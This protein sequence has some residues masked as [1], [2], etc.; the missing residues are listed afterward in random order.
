MCQIYA[1]RLLPI[2]FLLITGAA[3]AQ[4]SNKEN[5]P[6]SRY[7]IGDLVDGSNVLLRGMGYTS[8]SYSSGTAVN[9]D[10]P[11]SYASLRLTT[12]E[13]GITGSLR[14]I[15]VGGEKYNTGSATIANLN[16][17]IPLGKNGGLAL[18]LR[19]QSK[20]F[21]HN[22][23]SSLRFADGSRG[24]SDYNGDGGLNYA[25]IGAAGKYKGF[26]LGF[27]FGYMFGTIRNT[28]VTRNIDTT[29]LLSSDITRYTKIGGIYWKGGLQYE[30]PINNKLKLRVG[31]TATINQ[32]LNASREEYLSTFHY[33]SGGTLVTDTAYHNSDIS[34]KVTLPLSISGGVMLG[35]DKWSASVDY[36]NTNWSQYRNYGAIDSVADHTSRISVGGEYTPNATAL[37]AYL[38]RITYRLGFYY[39][40]DYVKLRNTDINYYAV[41]LGGSLPFK[42]SAD[43]IHIAA[44]IGQRGTETNNLVKENFFRF[45]LGISL[46]S[47]WFEKRR[48]D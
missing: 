14:T 3:S 17:G 13:A 48:Y 43:R 30:T 44:E 31:A 27:N 29:V 42:R 32:D 47:K 4:N 15:R 10:N 1:K 35:G 12:Y 26:S 45:H 25:F 11:A 6:Y 33:T 16:V 40:T 34:G 46:N 36:T 9:T 38:P 22:V 21:Y 39:G 18:G 19:P 37:Y 8:T 41:T 20:V 28:S 5:A 23:D 2:L 24:V 7:G